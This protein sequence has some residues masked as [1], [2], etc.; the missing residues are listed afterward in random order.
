MYSFLGSDEDSE[1]QHDHSR[2]QNKRIGLGGIRVSSSDEI[3]HFRASHSS[4]LLTLDGNSSQ[5]EFSRVFARERDSDR[6]GRSHVSR[7][8]EH[9]LLI[10]LKSNTDW[11]FSKRTACNLFITLVVSQIPAQ[12]RRPGFFHSRDL[13]RTLGSNCCSRSATWSTSRCSSWGT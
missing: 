11:I 13:N 6:T 7:K 1:N 2:H 8:E 3:R 12:G 5:V 10:D 9:V 4:N